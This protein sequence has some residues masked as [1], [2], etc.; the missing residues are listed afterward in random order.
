MIVG[1]DISRN[2]F[3]ASWIVSGK[4][5]NKKYDYTELGVKSFSND[6]PEDAL[7]LM[8]ATGVYHTLLALRLYESKRQ[9][10]VCNPLVIKRY[11]QMKLIRAKTDKADAR[12]IRMFGE[13]NNPSLW[14]PNSEEI[15]ELKQAH[16]WLN[17]Q[18]QERTRLLNRQEAHAHQAQKSTFVEKQM[19]R[20]LEALNQQI[21]DC[22]KHLEVIVKKHFADL[23]SR[24]ITIPSI[25]AK[26]ALELI[27]IT[28]GFS[29][30]EDIKSLS[31]YV[32]V[33]PTNHDSGISV[34]GKGHIAK[35]G[36][37]RIRQL[38]YICSWTAKTCN[39]SCKELSIRM[40]KKGK[41]S[42]VINIAIAHKLLRQAFAVAVNNVEY[43]E[44]YA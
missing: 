24:L 26:T 6:T 16:G 20:Q 35:M 31:A 30:F 32:G 41:P 7:F 14:S 25:G 15:N 44:N 19:R 38:L 29:R 37:G 2:S 1:I 36:N 9:V 4:E 21:K 3:D 42:K 11:S 5:I 43:S 34:K 28:G 17:D 18:I 22:E 33:S 13:E 12:L 40:A 23:Y 10:S 8:E 39:P 27:I